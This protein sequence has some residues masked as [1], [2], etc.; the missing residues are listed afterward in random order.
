MTVYQ[1]GSAASFELTLPA[2]ASAVTVTI[3]TSA[4]DVL[5]G[6]TAVGIAHL[7]V[8]QYLY[9]WPIPAGQADGGYVLT[10]DATV[11]GQ[12]EESQDPF[13]V[14]ASELPGTWCTVADVALL[15]GATVTQQDVNVAQQMI[16]GLDRRVW[17]ITDATKRDFYW[18]KRAVAWQARYVAA[19]PEVLDMMDVQSLSQDGLS[20]TFKSST[21]QMIA[22]YSPVALRFLNNLFR[23]SNSTIRLNSAFQKNRPPRGTLTG[24]SSVPWR[25]I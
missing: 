11:G 19:H 16:E 10:W 4:G 24:G 6:P 13:T 2:D 3:A 8:G 12:P 22:L 21:G 14:S 18:L 1:P 5:L 25:S 17:R 9:T 7:A 15:A 23:G 20:I